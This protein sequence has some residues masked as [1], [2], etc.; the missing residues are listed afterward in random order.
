MLIPFRKQVMPSLQGAWVIYCSL[1]KK[2]C[3]KGNSI[4]TR[5]RDFQRVRWT[6]YCSIILTWITPENYIMLQLENHNSSH[7]YKFNFLCAVCEIIARWQ[8]HLL[9]P[10]NSS[11]S[12]NFL[13]DSGTDKV[14]GRVIISNFSSWMLQQRQTLQVT[15]VWRGDE[16]ILSATGNMPFNSSIT[17]CKISGTSCWLLKLKGDLWSLVILFLKAQRKLE[18]SIGLV[19]HF[20]RDISRF[21]AL[22]KGKIMSCLEDS[23]K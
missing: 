14:K 3:W 2:W 11:G 10:V 20:K 4:S 23:W 13:M 17:I 7:L 18:G 22:D 21:T 8:N 16:M 5:N 19:L 15:D 1:N 12:R 6:F 9:A